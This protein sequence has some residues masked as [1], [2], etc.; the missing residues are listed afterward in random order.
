[1]GRLT[2]VLRHLRV[3]PGSL[4]SSGTPGHHLPDIHAS[5]YDDMK[6]HNAETGLTNDWHR[7]RPIFYQ[8]LGVALMISRELLLPSHIASRVSRAS[9]IASSRWRCSSLCRANGPRNQVLKG[10]AI[11]ETPLNNTSPESHVHRK[12]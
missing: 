10:F 1:M 12:G 3:A 7:K 2:F 8:A 5:F 11:L 4:S 6:E 9:P